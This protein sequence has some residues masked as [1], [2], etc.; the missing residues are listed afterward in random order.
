MDSELFSELEKLESIS[1]EKQEDVRQK[2]G[3]I[4]K[5]TERVVEISVEIEMLR[6]QFNRLEKLLMESRDYQK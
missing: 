6:K 1:K 4:N 2:Y 5:K 3:E